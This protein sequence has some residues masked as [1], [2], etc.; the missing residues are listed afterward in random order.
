MCIDL[1]LILFFL[2]SNIKSLSINMEVPQSPLSRA[3]H[4]VITQSPSAD[5]DK[6]PVLASRELVN[7]FSKPPGMKHKIPHRFINILCM[8][9]SKCCAC[10]DSLHFGRTIAKCQGN[11]SLIF[12]IKLRE[13]S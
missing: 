2:V 12:V 10:L 9:S 3:M 8:R 6:S 13:Y 4:C 1:C 7:K 11:V 5:H